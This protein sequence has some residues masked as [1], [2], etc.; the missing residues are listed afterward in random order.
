MLEWAAQA[1]RPCGIVILSHTCAKAD[2]RDSQPRSG[3]RPS[4]P[5][6]RTAAAPSGSTP[7]CGRT[8]CTSLAP[9]RA[10]RWLGNGPSGFVWDTVKSD[11]MLGGIPCRAHHTAGRGQ[12]LAL[13][14][15]TVAWRWKALFMRTRDPMRHGGHVALVV[16]KMAR[17]AAPAGKVRSTVARDSTSSRPLRPTFHLCSTRVRVHRCVPIRAARHDAGGTP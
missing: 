12:P 4:A 3:R 7:R 2:G 5:R 15:A 10:L 14:G 16:G 1:G 13:D 17:A 6:R 11:T 8:S 9:A